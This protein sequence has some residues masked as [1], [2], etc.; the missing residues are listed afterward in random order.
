MAK[1]PS[2]VEIGGGR[3]YLVASQQYCIG[4][5]EVVYLCSELSCSNGDRYRWVKYYYC[6]EI[7][8]ARFGSCVMK[9]L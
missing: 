5:F 3:K 1:M 7:T 8:G 2:K 4:T 9:N 6:Q